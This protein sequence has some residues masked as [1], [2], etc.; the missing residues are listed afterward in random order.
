MQRLKLNSIGE[1]FDLIDQKG[2]F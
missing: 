1:L 2:F